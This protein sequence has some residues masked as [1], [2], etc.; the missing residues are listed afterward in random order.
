MFV[1][2]AVRIKCETPRKELAHIKNFI[3]GRYYY[4]PY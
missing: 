1:P 4:Y 2:I 3:N